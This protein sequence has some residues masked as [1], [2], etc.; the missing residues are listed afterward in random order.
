MQMLIK[1]AQLRGKSALTDIAID[2]GTIVRMGTGLD[3][4]ADRVID[5]AHS[6]SS[7]LAGCPQVLGG[8]W[9]ILLW[10]APQRFSARRRTPL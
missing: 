5:V 3:V 9:A 6:F 1:N 4:A 7:A 10:R 2:D 8:P